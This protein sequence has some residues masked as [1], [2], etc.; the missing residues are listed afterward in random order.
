MD[1]GL[2]GGFSFSTL[3]DCLGMHIRL[4]R[5]QTILVLIRENSCDRIK[6]KGDKCIEKR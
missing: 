5:S 2:R 1:P 3:K 6:L 4:K